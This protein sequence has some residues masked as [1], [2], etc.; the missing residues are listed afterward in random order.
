M[1]A[2]SSSYSQTSKQTHGCRLQGVGKKPRA[3]S[4]HE[5]V[6]HV[7]AQVK[8]LGHLEADISF[9]INLIVEMFI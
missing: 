7:T 3:V 6:L 8:Q 2:A 5:M 4:R 9:S 1:N